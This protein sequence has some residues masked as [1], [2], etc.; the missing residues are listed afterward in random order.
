MR[1]SD[2]L[3]QIAGRL[4]RSNDGWTRCLVGYTAFSFMMIPQALIWKIHFGFFTMATLSRIRDKGAEPTVDEVLV[5]DTV[6]ANEKLAELFKPE[7]YHIID[8]D[9]EWDEGRTNPYFPELKS[10]SAK[11]FNA[12]RFC[13]GLIQLFWNKLEFSQFVF[14][15]KSLTYEIGFFVRDFNI[16]PDS[17][18]HFLLQ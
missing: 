17:H 15:H 1:L 7:S 13:F 18:I 2:Y 11:F 9:Q 4:H 8:Y 3:Y 16:Q 14:F 12:D 10:T 6:F 5:L